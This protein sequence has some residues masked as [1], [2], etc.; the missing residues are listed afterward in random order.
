MDVVVR[1]NFINKMFNY[2]IVNITEPYYK[3][4]FLFH[5]V[6]IKYIEKSFT[7]IVFG[8]STNYEK[9]KVEIVD[10]DE[11]SSTI[12]ITIIDLF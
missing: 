11:L 7:R 2:I 6:F 3:T 10:V 8:T 1:F 4:V 9:R 5:S 12:K